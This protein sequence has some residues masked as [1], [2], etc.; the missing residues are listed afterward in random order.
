MVD[1][2]RSV[3]PESWRRNLYVTAI[4]EFLVLLGFSLYVPFLPLYM[5]SVGGLGN[6]E[7][8]L[9]SGIATGLAGLAMF[10]SSP[11]W[12]VVADR[13][14]RKPMLLR[15]QF[16]GAAVAFLYV[17]SPNIY[18]LVGFRFLQG[19]FTGTVSAASA[20]IASTTPREKLPYSMGILM[21]A[22]F[23]GQTIGQL[24]GGFLAEHFG[25]DVAFYVAALLLLGGALTIL[26]L[27]HENFVQPEKGQSVSLPGML[28]IA[29]SPNVLPLL[30]VMAALGLGPMIISPILPLVFGA[31]S[32]DTGASIASGEAFALLGVVMAVSSLVF[33]RFHGRFSVR[34]VLAVCCIGAGLLS[35]PPIWAATSLQL[36]L[37]IGLSGIL[38]GGIITSSNSL[39]GTAVPLTQQGI[40]YGLSQ[41]ASSLGSG[42]GPFIGGGLAPLI[43]LRPIFGVSAVVMILVG[44]LSLKVIRK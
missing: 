17:I 41:S 5:K 9:W 24:L 19:L 43:G 32:Q 4:A 12:G 20:L 10:I 8:A 22:I 29:F 28:K 16:G 33:G 15:A 7:A 31:M 6:E 38:S 39:V 26:F 18:F 21:G 37:L 2:I 34:K 44:L 13:W 1:N 3:Q 23:G 35:L 11:I 40:A 36:I 42:I 27:V 30:M 25:Y 14:G